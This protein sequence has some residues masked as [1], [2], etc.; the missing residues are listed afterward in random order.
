MLET[1]WIP[2]IYVKRPGWAIFWSEKRVHLA[3]FKKG[4]INALAL[5]VRPESGFTFGTGTQTQKSQFEQPF[6]SRDLGPQAWTFWQSLSYI[7]D[8]QKDR[9]LLWLNFDETSV[10]YAPQCPTGC[11]VSRKHWKVNPHCTV[12]KEALGIK[13][14]QTLEPFST[15][16]FWPKGC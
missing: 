9:K 12:R 1:A 15:V 4:P 14:G 16:F 11:I 13:P 8:K 3:A 2:P 6:T 5:Q 7:A 10:A